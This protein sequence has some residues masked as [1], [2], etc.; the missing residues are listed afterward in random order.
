MTSSQIP[1]SLFAFLRELKANNDRSWFEAN[2]ERYHSEVR[3]P[4]LAF[5]DAFAGPL[6]EIS[7]HFRADPRPHGGSLFRIYRDTRFSKDKTPYKTNVGAHFRHVAGRN[8]H[9]PGFYLHLEPGACFA[10]GGLWRPDSRALGRVR[11]AIVDRTDE[12]VSVTA[13]ASFRETFEISGHSLKRPPRGYDPEHPLIDDIKRKD[14]VAIANFTESF[15]AQ[16]D[17]FRRFVAIV[18]TGSDFVRFL[19]RAVGVPY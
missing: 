5:I 14:F 17:F 2:K 1:R 3:D 15:A 18:R 6:S 19:S 8:A 9:A 7:P 12:W 16:P 10:G 11:D 13:D 4:M